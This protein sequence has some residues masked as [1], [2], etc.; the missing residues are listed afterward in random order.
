MQASSHLLIIAINRVDII[1]FNPKK[2]LT[3]SV[4]FYKT[5]L[6][7]NLIRLN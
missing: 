5:A 7:Y 6:F 2:T 4:L 1:Q 3:E